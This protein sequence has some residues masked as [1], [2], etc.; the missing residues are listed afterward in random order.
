MRKIIAPVLLAASLFGLQGC[1][2]SSNASNTTASVTDV[3]YSEFDSVPI[4]VDM[5][6]QSGYTNVLYNI[7]GMKSGSQI[8]EGPLERQSLVNAMTHNMLR[9]GWQARTIVSSGERNMMV[10]QNDNRMAVFTVSEGSTFSNKTV[11]DVW[12]APYL[13]DGVVKAK[14]IKETPAATDYSNPVNNPAFSVSPDQPTEYGVQEQGLN[15]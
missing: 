7:D 15:Q 5:I 10:F 13:P 1:V 8:F 11:M 2:T 3:Y 4:P 14:Q 12:V 9:K 6:E